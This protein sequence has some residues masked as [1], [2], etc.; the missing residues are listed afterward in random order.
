MAWAVLGGRAAP[1]RGAT[2]LPA[3]HEPGCR[4]RLW[5]RG[6]NKSTPGVAWWVLSG[7]Q[8]TPVRRL[9]FPGPAA[10]SCVTAVESRLVCLSC[11][12]VKWG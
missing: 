3:R 7:V 2:V 4:V 10:D 1:C 9:R 5:N 6:G 11:L 12:S 8:Q